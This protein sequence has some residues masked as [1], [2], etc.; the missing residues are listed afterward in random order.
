[1]TTLRKAAK[2]ALSAI[3]DSGHKADI[4]VAADALREALAVPEPDPLTDEEIQ[5]IFSE[6][7]WHE[8]GCA[9]AFARAIERAHG[10]GGNDE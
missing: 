3:E 1:M 4:M 5:A 2:L 9:I 8:F 10:I 6:I 7:K